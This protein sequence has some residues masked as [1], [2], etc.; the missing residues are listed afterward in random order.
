MK[1]RLRKKLHRKEFK[2]IGFDFKISFTPIYDDE[3]RFNLIDDIYLLIEQHGFDAGGSCDDGSCSGFMAVQ[4]CRI[5][6][7]VMKNSLLKALQTLP[8]I[9]NVIFGENIDAWYGPFDD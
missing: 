8:K 1:K 5:D 9:T 6:A 7:D 4:D 2:E 3:N